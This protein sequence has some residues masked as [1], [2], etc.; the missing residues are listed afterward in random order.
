MRFAVTI[1]ETWTKTFSIDSDNAIAA[2]REAL[3]Q[4]QD[5]VGLSVHEGIALDSDA[6]RNEFRIQKIEEIK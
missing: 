4:Y 5:E 1:A 2:G 6:K 3:K